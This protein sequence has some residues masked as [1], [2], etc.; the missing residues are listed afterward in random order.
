LELTFVHVQ[1]AVVLVFRLAAPAGH[2]H[3]GRGGGGGDG[4]GNA[5]GGGGTAPPNTVGITGWSVM[6]HWLEPRSRRRYPFS[7]QDLPLRRDDAEQN[8]YLN[9]YLNSFTNNKISP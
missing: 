2:C 8:I 3:A 5:G 7:P 1:D 4:G 9:G 6:P